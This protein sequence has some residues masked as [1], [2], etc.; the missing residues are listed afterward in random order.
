MSNSIS[1]RLRIKTLVNKFGIFFVFIS[2]VIFFSLR[3]PAFL[4]INNLMNVARQ[5][6]MLGITAVGMMFVIIT[7]GIDLSVGSLMAFTNVVCAYLMVRLGMNPIIAS[8]LCLVFCGLCGFINGFI[9][10]KFRVPPIISSMGLMNILRG[11]AFIISRGLPIY[12]FTPNFKILGQ[13]YLGVIPI[14]VI[15]MIMIFSLGWFIINETPFGR[16]VYAI[17]GN[18]EASMLSGI[19]VIAT[20][21][22]VYTISGVFAGIASLIMLSRL[23]SGQPT[24]GSGF[25]FEVII[26]VVLGGV[27]VSGGSGRVFGVIMGVLIMGVL[28]NGLIL[29]NVNDYVQDVVMGTVLIFAVAFD[30]ISKYRNDIKLKEAI[31]SKGE[32]VISAPN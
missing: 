10:T 6:S 22:A 27:S 1:R 25:E 31:K 30:C 5:V 12:G 21:Q 8:I 9:I 18:E 14:P 11:L 3:T 29:I 19:N 28:S 20:K 4:K 7:G 2:L 23:N 17:G 32:Q 13:G 26:S 24:T 15:I 16:Y